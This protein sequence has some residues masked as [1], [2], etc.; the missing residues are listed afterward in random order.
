M[1]PPP[2]DHSRTEAELRARAGATVTPEGLGGVEA[3]RVFADVLAPSCI[4]TDHPRFF[5]FVPAAPTEAAMLFDLVVGSSALYGGSWMEG[6]GAVFAENEA[7]RWLADLAGFPLSAGGVF[8]SGGSAGNLSALVAARHRWRLARPDRAAVRGAVLAS[9]AA[10]SSLAAAARVMDADVVPV[11]ADADGRL[12]ASA[13]DDVISAGDLDRVFAVVATAG[14]TNAGLVDDLGAAADAADELGAWLHVDGAYGL[15]ALAVPSVRSLFAGI[16]R[17]DSFVVDPHKWLFA[18]FDCAALVYRDPSIARATF[19]Q[20]A[21][22]LEVVNERPDWN[23]SDYAYHLTRRARGLPFWFSLA[24]HG[25]RRYAEAIE[26]TLVLTRAAADLVRAT[27]YLELLLEPELSVVVFRRVGWSTSE[28]YAWSEKLL[29]DGVA[30]V[31]PT[32]WEGETALR[33]C[34]VNPCT[35]VDDVRVVLDALA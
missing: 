19:T 13:L 12:T 25:T 33:C 3:L 1:D 6:S 22:Y 5:S 15:A 34:F 27:P 23:P 26:T 17:A 4:S 28:Y 7:L 18:P 31:V 9:T 16:E 29:V 24:T 30:F 11:P 10:H 35:T 21:E 2:L 14:T 20:H 32:M 8:V